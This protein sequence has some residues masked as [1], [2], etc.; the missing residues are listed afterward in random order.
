MVAFGCEPLKP[1][2]AAMWLFIDQSILAVFRSA[3]STL[4]LRAKVPPTGVGK[5][6]DKSV[7]KL[8]KDRA[9]GRSYW[10]A[11]IAALTVQS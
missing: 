8:W 9:E 2:L 10:L 11:A 5:P 7:I 1:G 4:F 3:L 6:V